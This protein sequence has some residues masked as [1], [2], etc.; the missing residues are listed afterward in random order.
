[1]KPTPDSHISI[2]AMNDKGP[3]PEAAIG[4]DLVK[5]GLIVAPVMLGVCAIFWAPMARGLAP[6]AWQLCLETSHLRPFLSHSR[7]ESRMP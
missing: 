5:H 2:L 1:M 6:M 4:R 3:A 7:L